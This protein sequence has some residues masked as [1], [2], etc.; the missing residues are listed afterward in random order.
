MAAVVESAPNPVRYLTTR[1]VH[2]Y[3]G[4]SIKEL[5]RL[6]RDGGG[7]LFCNPS[8]KIVRYKSTDVDAWLEKDKYANTG[9]AAASRAKRKAAM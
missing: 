3:T 5:E 9:Q 4:I 7:P 2:E 8:P 6:R 1:E